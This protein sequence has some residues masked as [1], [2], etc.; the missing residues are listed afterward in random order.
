MS[1]MCSK[2][3]DTL[4]S[5]SFVQPWHQKQTKELKHAPVEA[6][7]AQNDVWVSFIFADVIVRMQIGWYHSLDFAVWLSVFRV[8]VNEVMR[9]LLQDID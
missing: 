5:F 9:A 6:K 2:L 3:L 4:L 1:V 8:C 7:H